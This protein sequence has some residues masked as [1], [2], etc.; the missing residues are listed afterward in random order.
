MTAT[1]RRR[2]QGVVEQVVG[3]GSGGG[4]F[5]RLRSCGS[6]GVVSESTLVTLHLWGVPSRAVPR[7]VL[8]MA[9]DRAPLRRTPGLRFAKLLGTGSGRTFTPRDADPRRWGVLAVWDD[10]SAATAFDQG[11]VVRAWRR[12]AQEEWVA[13]LRPLSARGQWSRQE[14]FGRPTPYR[15][16]GRVAAVTRARLVLHRA[17]RF[18]RAVPPVTVDLHEAPGL[19]LALGI[20]EAPLGL[21]GTFSIWTSSAALNAFAYDRAAHKGVIERTE[22]ERW[23]AEE[24][25]ARLGVLSTSGTLGGV[26][27]LRG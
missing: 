4:V 22:R 21:Q 16:E 1:S 6:L 2:G 3:R 5:P 27:P 8:H 25:F 19:R 18:W 13:R 9:A 12:F 17:V 14:P 26:D 7:A 23:Y 24:L 10:A 11:D 20:G 15:W